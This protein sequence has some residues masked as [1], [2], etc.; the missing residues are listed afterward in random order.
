MGP[1][2]DKAFD[3]IDRELDDGHMTPAEH[4]EALRDLRGEMESYASDQAE[5]AYNDAMGYW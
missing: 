3:E 4:R 2:W 1:N 5:N